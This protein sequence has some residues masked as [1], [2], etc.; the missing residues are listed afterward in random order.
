V[1]LNSLQGSQ[2][3]LYFACREGH[4]KVVSALV[5]AGAVVDTGDGVSAV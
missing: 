5:S 2:T 1:S 3:A 4:A